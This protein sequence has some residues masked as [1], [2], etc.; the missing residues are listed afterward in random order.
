M[1]HELHRHEA[2]VPEGQRWRSAYG[3]RPA[4]IASIT[5]RVR[6]AS[7]DPASMRNVKPRDGAIVCAL[8]APPTA[9]SS[10][11]RTRVEQFA[12][13]VVV[14]ILRVV[15]TRVPGQEFGQACAR[16]GRRQ[17]Q[18]L[19]DD[20]VGLRPRTP[21]TPRRDS[22]PQ[23]GRSSV[24]ARSSGRSSAGRNRRCRSCTKRAQPLERSRIS[25]AL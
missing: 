12:R 13:E 3:P 17:V 21:A 18:L 4:S 6:R 14:A 20:P 22:P 25:I 2:F 11:S 8:I 23:C 10:A 15:G 24:R 1:A 16:C 19:L 9:A 5:R 7:G